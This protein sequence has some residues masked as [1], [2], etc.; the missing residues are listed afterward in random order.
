MMALMALNWA[1]LIGVT[2]GKYGWDV[3][4]PI[5]YLS[6][7]GVDLAAMAGVFDL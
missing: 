7:L 6:A 2:Y 4:E 1:F 5:S 3:G